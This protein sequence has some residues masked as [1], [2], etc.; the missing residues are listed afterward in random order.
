MK[1]ITQKYPN[2]SS[3]IPKEAVTAT[4]T[5]FEGLAADALAAYET[6]YLDRVAQQSSLSVELEQL[7]LAGKTKSYQFK[8][9]MGKKLA[10]GIIIR[11][12]EEALENI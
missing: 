2:G 7:R 6:L 1:I 10:N 5:N 11:A 4:E 9:L 8:E 12:I 3:Y